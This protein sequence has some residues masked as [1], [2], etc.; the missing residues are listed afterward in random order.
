VGVVLDVFVV[1]VVVVVLLKLEVELFSSCY[2]SGRI[3]S[4]S[5]I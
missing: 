5:S 2:C 3:L 1:V 4:S